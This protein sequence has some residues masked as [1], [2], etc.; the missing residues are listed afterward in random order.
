[1]RLLYGIA[2]NFSSSP[3]SSGSRKTNIT[4]IIP[5]VEYMVNNQ[6]HFHLPKGQS[7]PY[8]HGRAIGVFQLV[9]TQNFIMPILF[10]REFEA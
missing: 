4:G 8:V 5:A 2:S 10:V 6:Y 9:F 7:L 1:M 3:A